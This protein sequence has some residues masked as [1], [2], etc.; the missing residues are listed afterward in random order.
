MC[1]QYASFGLMIQVIGSTMI[2]IRSIHT[3]TNLALHDYIQIVD[4][5]IDIHRRPRTNQMD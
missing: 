2:Y 4:L 5:I 1:V 3:Q